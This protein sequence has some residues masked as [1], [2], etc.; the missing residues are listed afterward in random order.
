MPIDYTMTGTVI[1]ES[2]IEDRLLAE[3]SVCF[4]LAGRP[5]PWNGGE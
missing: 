4:W 5:L 2:W 1:G 3:L